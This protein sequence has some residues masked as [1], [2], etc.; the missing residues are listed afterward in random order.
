MVSDRSF[1]SD[2]PVCDY[3]LGHCEGFV[4]RAGHRTLGVVDRVDHADGARLAQTV[5][6]RKRRRRRALDAREVLAVVPARK[7]IL[8]RRREH[9]RPALRRAWLALRRGYAVAAPVVIAFAIGLRKQAARLAHLTA[10]EIRERNR[11]RIAPST[12]RAHRAANRYTFALN[13]PTREG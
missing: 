13:S 11:R 10:A 5:M 9:A 12:R 8:A 2:S 4:V 1:P 6:I 7:V 3:W